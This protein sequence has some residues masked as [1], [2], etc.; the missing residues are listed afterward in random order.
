MPVAH[1]PEAVYVS[2]TGMALP[3]VTHPVRTAEELWQ[4][5]E[6]G[7]SCLSE[8]YNPDVP[9]RIAGQVPGWK[10]EE[11]LDVPP[12][13]ARRMARVTTLAVSAVRQALHAASLTATDVSGVRTVLVVASMQFAS[14]ENERFL[15]ALS[16]GG[17]AELGMD[18]WLTGTPG[19]VASGLSSVLDIEAPTL[20]ITGGCNCSLRAL[21]VAH[22][23]LHCGS[24]DRAIVVGADAALDPIFLAS[25]VHEGSNGFRASTL[26]ADPSAVRPHDEQQDG[27]APGEGAIAIVL[28]RSRGLPGAGMGPVRLGFRT[29]RR[30]GRNPVDVG[31]P[32]N[33]AADVTAL[34]EDGDVALDRMAFINGFA[35]GTRNIENLF[36][37]AM[38]LLREQCDYSGTLTL[39]NQEAA[40][41][42]IS[43]CSGLIKFVSTLLMFEHGTVGPAVGCRQPYRRLNATPLTIAAPVEGRHALVIS[44]GA[45]GDATSLLIERD[46]G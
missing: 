44:T 41:G 23:M 22:M 32:D 2:G 21:E 31:E 15:N 4:V 13:V 26:S 1:K 30:N 37:G 9:L 29:S 18:Y 7:T 6:S 38:D 3:G 28:E 14:Q 34:L 11:E 46:N 5:V 19:S 40:F 25:T 16:R 43:G 24:A 39:T 12:K 45:G 20:N 35:E 42:H 8:F 17:S 36:C 27:N 33:I 10:P